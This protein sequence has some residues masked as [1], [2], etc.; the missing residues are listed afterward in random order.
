MFVTTPQTPW[1]L[2]Q[3]DLKREGFAYDSAQEMAVQHLQR[4]YDDLVAYEAGLNKFSVQ[5]F[6][7]KVSSKKPEPIKGLYFGAEWAR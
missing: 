6:I 4:L 5:R 1:E 2:Y 3:A 7:N